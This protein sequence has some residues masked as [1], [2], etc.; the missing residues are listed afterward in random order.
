MLLVPPSTSRRL[1]RNV[2]REARGGSPVCVNGAKLL[3]PLGS[4]SDPRR[5]GLSGLG[6]D[7]PLLFGVS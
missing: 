5:M 4:H 7:S 6:P 3:R 1:R 2:A